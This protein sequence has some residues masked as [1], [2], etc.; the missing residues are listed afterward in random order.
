LLAI[1]LLDETVFGVRQAAWPAIQTDFHLSYAAIGLLLTLPSLV[2]AVLQPALGLLADTGRRR[3][4]VALGGVAFATALLITAFAWVFL[5]LLIGFLILDTASG[6]FVALSQAALVDLEPERSEQSMARWVLAGSVGVVAGPLLLAG[7]L[8]LGLDWRPLFVA[9]ALLTLPLVLLA[10]GTPEGAAS[11]AGLRGVVRMAARTLRQ[12]RI[13]RW[14][15]VLQLTDLMG[16]VFAGFL[17]LYLVNVATVSPLTAAAALTL[18]SGTTLLGDALLLPLLAR[19]RGMTY[20]R[21]SAALVLV[22]F[23][24]LLLAPSLPVKLLCIALLGLLH[25]G[26]YA[27]PQGRLFAELPGA[28]GTAVAI[29]DLASFVGHLAPLAIGLAAERAGLG[30]ALWL[31]L[32]APLSLLLCLP[33]D[34]AAPESNARDAS[35]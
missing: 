11:E 32:L 7:A 28:S 22:T 3:I 18:W 35:P 33:R 21:C 16:D 27:I 6:A 9:L 31:L 19:V 13:L 8:A 1:E 25:A 4:I 23:P 14:L 15:L 5:T 29:A 34:H 17:A 10:R 24:V 26:W 2:G 20:L 30:A 12:A